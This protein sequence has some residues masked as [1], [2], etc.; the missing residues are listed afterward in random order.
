MKTTSGKGAAA[1]TRRA[2]MAPGIVRA[3]QPAPDGK[4]GGGNSG[5]LGRRYLGRQRTVARTGRRRHSGTG[6]HAAFIPAIS[7][8]LRRAL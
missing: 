6:T 2:V 8:R 4:A 5:W 1:S 3:A 7:F